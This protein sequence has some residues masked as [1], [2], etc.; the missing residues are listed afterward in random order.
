MKVGCVFLVIMYF[1]IFPKSFITKCNIDCALLLICLLSAPIVSVI[2][3]IYALLTLED[4]IAKYGLES[5]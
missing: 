3:E 4:N 2:Q 1:K 5:A